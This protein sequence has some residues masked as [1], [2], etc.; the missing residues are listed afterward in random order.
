MD[1]YS[2]DLLKIQILFM[3]ADTK[4]Q[5]ISTKVTDKISPEMMENSETASLLRGISLGIT[6]ISNTILHY[7]EWDTDGLMYPITIL[8]RSVNEHYCR[9]MYIFFNYLDNRN[10]DNKKE[11]AAKKFKENNSAWETRQMFKKLR[12]I[13]KTNEIDD[14]LKT[15]IN[16][17]FEDPEKMSLKS[18]ELSALNKNYS[19]FEIT[20]YLVDHKHMTARNQASVLF[21]YNNSHPFVHGGITQLGSIVHYQ[22]DKQSESRRIIKIARDTFEINGFSTSYYLEYFFMITDDKDFKIAQTEIISIMQQL[23]QDIKDS[24]PNI[25]IK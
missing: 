23:R 7:L 22:N 14:R 12:A 16:E 8:Y 10:D 21:E 9:L 25:S 17:Y 6:T 20:K 19:V 18:K 1:N 4:M 24:F 5:E 15:I 11:D 3:E 2:D 13:A